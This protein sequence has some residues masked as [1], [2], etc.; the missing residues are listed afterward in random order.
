MKAC[1]RFTAGSCELRS[2][3]TR[4]PRTARAERLCTR[5]H[6]RQCRSGTAAG[7]SITRPSRPEHGGRTRRRPRPGALHREPTQRP[8]RRGWPDHPPPRTEQPAIHPAGT[9][10][11]G[12]R[13]S[14]RT[15]RAT[16]PHVRRGRR[17]DEQPRPRRARG[18]AHSMSGAWRSASVTTTVRPHLRPCPAAPSLLAPVRLWRRC[19]P[20]DSVG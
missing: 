5:T 18:A 20:A 12:P 19:R 16:H 11:R 2:A 8:P 10:R 14:R 1:E 7:A 15:G 4:H 3:G 17:P 6:G 13:H 9:H